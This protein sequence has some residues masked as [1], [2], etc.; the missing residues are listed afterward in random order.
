M[1]NAWCVPI[2]GSM[3]SSKMPTHLALGCVC[4]PRPMARASKRLRRRM[5]GVWRAPAASTTSGARTSKRARARP[6][7]PTRRPR[8]PTARR[9]FHSTRSTRASVSSAAPARER[10]RHLRHVHRLLGA[11]R[12]AERAVVEPD[13]AP[14]VAR[15]ARQRPAERFRA[16]HEEVRVLPEGVLVVRLRVQDA[17]GR[18]RSTAPWRAARVPP[19]R[20][21][22]PSVP[23]TGSGVRHDMPPLITVEPPTHRPSAK[24]I[25]GLPR[26]IARARVAVEA[27][28]HR[29]R[30]G[31]E[32]LGAVELA[33]LEHEDVE[34]GVA[35]PGRGGGAAGAGADHDGV[36]VQHLVADR[37]ARRP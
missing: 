14:H 11:R 22:A 13:A 18:R 28:D 9:P 6:S 1:W 31:G 37:A 30:I 12:T 10:P 24:M 3:R 32:G 17:L 35:Q 26:I 7:S 2:Q 4:R 34:P 33:F 21:R 5:P 27:A 8:T 19:G 20:G 25:G 29:R 36:G 16:A 15:R 23:S